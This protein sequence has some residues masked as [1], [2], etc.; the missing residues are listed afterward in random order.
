MADSTGRLSI[1]AVAALVALIRI[2]RRIISPGLLPCC[3][4]TPSCSTYALESLQKHG[5]VKGLAKATWRVCR[6]HPL[7]RAGYDPP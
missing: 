7:G 3:R 5:V 1:W 6:C 2:Y 4:F